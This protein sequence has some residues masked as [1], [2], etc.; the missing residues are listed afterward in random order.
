MSALRKSVFVAASL[1]QVPHRS[2][3]INK[4]SPAWA[5]EHIKPPKRL[6]FRM[7]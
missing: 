1:P 3:K 6:D 7:L 5:E 2:G 4:E